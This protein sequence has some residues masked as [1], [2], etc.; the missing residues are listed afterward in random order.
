MDYY[1]E[2]NMIVM[3]RVGIEHCGFDY[4]LY[5][6]ELFMCGIEGQDEISPARDVDVIVIFYRGGQDEEVG[7]ARCDNALKAILEQG[8]KEGLEKLERVADA[9]RWL[10]RDHRHLDEAYWK[11]AR[12]VDAHPYPVL[13]FE[14]HDSVQEMMAALEELEE[15]TNE[16]GD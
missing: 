6:S 3:G 12:L 15:G 10:L 8:E 14:D 5:R 16:T 11:I 13:E 7:R 2:Q 4:N 9:A 1:E